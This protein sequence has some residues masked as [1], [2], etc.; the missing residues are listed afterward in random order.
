MKAVRMHGFGGPD[1]L[2]VDELPVPALDDDE[3]LVK[4]CAAGVNPVDY[5]VRSGKF[6]IVEQDE[7]PAIL[8]RDISG[9]V[10]RCGV[11][12][13][14]LHEG[15]QVYALLDR[16]HGGYV[17]Y[18][19]IKAEL[20]A[21]KPRSLSHEQAAAV[22]LAGLTAW[23]GLFDQGDLAAGESVLIHGGGGGVGHLAIQF[24]KAAGATVYTTCAAEDMALVRELGADRA[25]EY[26]RERFEDRVPEVDM[27]FDL[28][29]GETQTRSWSVLKQGGRLVSTL[30]QPAQ[31]KARERH[32]R[33]VVYMAQSSAAELT[34]IAR[35]IDAGRVRPWLQAEL[36]L[37]Q[38]AA[39]Q[40][41]LEHEHAQGKIVLKVAA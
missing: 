41:R 15:D 29:G 3:A 17:E 26:R 32:A 31:D 38:A 7:L 5:K 36:P 24:A 13:R 4:V 16:D 22:P 30:Q 39:A 20:C 19:A 9:V 40:D 35:L 1:V 11:A 14:S 33:G 37:D 2:H 21:E 10:Q 23:Q 6:P 25:I 12:V 27:V 8:G 18:V 34:Q 28:V